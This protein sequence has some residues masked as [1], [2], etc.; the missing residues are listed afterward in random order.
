[1]LSDLRVAEVTEWIPAIVAVVVAV[2]GIFGTWITAR[3]QRQKTDA[4]ATSVLTSVALQLIEPLQLRVSE[5]EAEIG[6]MERKILNLEKE[7]ALLHKWA[8]LLYTQ[9]VETGHD[10]ISFER[11]RN[12]EP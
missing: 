4:D 1:M 12:L 10:P 2:G 11:V 6:R 9:V 3:S 5:M 7:N 8:Q